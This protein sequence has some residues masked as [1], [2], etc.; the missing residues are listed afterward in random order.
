[1]RAAGVPKPLFSVSAK[2]RLTWV[3]TGYVL[4]DLFFVI[5][6]G[7]VVFYSRF[8]PHWMPRMLQGE[9]ISV[10]DYPFVNDYLAFLFLYAALILM[11]CWSQGLYKTW[12]THSRVD[13]SMS[14]VIAVGLATLLLMAF[15]FISGIS[16]ISRLV[17]AFSSLLNAGTLIAWRLWRH[18]VVERQV[19]QGHGTKNVLILGAGIIGQELASYLERNKHLGFVVKGF[20]D[21]NPPQDSRVLGVF[22]DFSQ[23]VRTQFVDQVFIAGL[24]RRSI[25]RDILAVARPLRIN[26]GLIPEVYEGA[27][28]ESTFEYFGNFPVLNLH[29]EPI[30]VVGLLLKRVTDIVLSGLG[31]M[32]IS[33]LMIFIALMIK[34]DSPGP[35]IYQDQRIGKKGRRFTCYKYRTMVANASELKKGL[36]SKSDRDGAFFKIENDPRVTRI[37]R[38]LRKY[39]LDEVP[40]LWNV[41]KG[42]MSLVGPRPHPIDDYER[43]ALE[44]LRRLDVLPGMTGLWQIYAR[45]NPHF[46]QNMIFDLQYIDQWSYVLDIKI[47]IKTIPA[48]WG[49]TGV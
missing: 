9:L 38:V 21:D 46:E 39:S 17:V 30:P 5:L 10:P 48:V 31:G 28:G 43:Y 14:V 18:G 23:V 16:S 22:E 45:Q 3:S 13:E 15:I 26:V 27:T 44:D 24:S 32:V 12:H 33:P 36:R 1:M 4:A 11:A 41:M 49:G 40:Q 42:D 20:L 19:A 25:V 35:V 37:G 34:L 7:A 47:L 8:I 29:E 6:S 2:P